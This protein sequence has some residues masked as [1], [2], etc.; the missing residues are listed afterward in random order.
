VRNPSRTRMETLLRA[1][2][3][4]RGLFSAAL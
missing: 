2:L 4:K 3:S 1:L